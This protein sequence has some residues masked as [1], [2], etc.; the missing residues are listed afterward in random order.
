[1]RT[2]QRPRRYVAR[3]WLWL[4][5]PLFR[6]SHVREAFVLRGVGSSF[7]PVLRAERRARRRTRFKGAERR[8]AIA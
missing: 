1:M 3:H 2:V 5:R 6:Y 8:R 7:G 4:L